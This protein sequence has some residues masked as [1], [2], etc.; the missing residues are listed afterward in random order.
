MPDAVII[1][2]WISKNHGLI[3]DA[4]T[5]LE[6]KGFDVDDLTEV[7]A[8]FL[9]EGLAHVLETDPDHSERPRKP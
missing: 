8:I 2:E 7:L 6:E 3:E 4:A 9:E 1:R 5:L